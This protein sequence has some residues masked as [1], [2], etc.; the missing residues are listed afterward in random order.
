MNCIF[1]KDPK[2]VDLEELRKLMKG[3]QLD[4]PKLKEYINARWLKYVEWWDSRAA[5]AK[6]K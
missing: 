5:K 2:L 1:E 3:A 4:D 6:W